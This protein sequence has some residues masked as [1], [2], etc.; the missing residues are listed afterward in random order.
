MS[1]SPASSFRTGI[2]VLF[3]A[4]CALLTAITV[5]AQGQQVFKGQIIQCTCPGPNARAGA[6]D[7]AGLGAGC[8]FPCAIPGGRYVL[9]DVRNKVI[10]Q[11]DKQDFAKAYAGLNVYV[12]GILDPPTGTIQVNNIVPDVTPKAKQAKSASIVCDA[13]PRAMSKAKLAAFEE[14]TVW[15]RFTLISDPKK[16][17]V[18]FLF[19]ANPYLGDYVTRDG[20]DTRVTR[21]ETVYLNVIDPRNGENLWSDNQRV[22]SFFISSATK[23]LIREF[24]ELLEADVNPQERKMFA[25]RNRVPKIAINEGK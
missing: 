23:D 20:P 12:I 3:L 18:V 11:F 9:S 14:L 1:N 8:G 15:K 19:S 24:R 10:L 21:V 4:A 13:C 6:G 17:D 22:G 2:W 5:S 25:E 16:A 7:K